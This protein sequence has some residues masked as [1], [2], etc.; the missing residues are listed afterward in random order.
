MLLYILLL[1]K[2]NKRQMP[3][4]KKTTIALIILDVIK[5]LEAARVFENSFFPA[6]TA[7]EMSVGFINNDHFFCHLCI[8]FTQ[9]T[10]SQC[11]QKVLH[12]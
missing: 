2:L 4:H 11:K 8:K 5:V 10:K 9:T 6:Q 1:N 3:H 7:V 12:C